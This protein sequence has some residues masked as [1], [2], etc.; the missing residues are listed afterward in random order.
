MADEQERR[1]AAERRGLAE[2]IPT[3]GEMALYQALQSAR[4][5]TCQIESV[6]FVLSWGATTK[7]ADGGVE[8]QECGVL[9]QELHQILVWKALMILQAF[10]PRCHTAR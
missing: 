10:S 8:S 6:W 1:K 2:I 7:S 4:L 5:T 9:I 3:N